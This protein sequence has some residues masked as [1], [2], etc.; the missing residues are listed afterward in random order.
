MLGIR[1]RDSLNDS[2]SCETLTAYRR[3]ISGGYRPCVLDNCYRYS[4]WPTFQATLCGACRL[5]AVP[6]PY[7]LVCRTSRRRHSALVTDGETPLVLRLRVYR[8]GAS[9]PCRG[10]SAALTGPA[11]NAMIMPA[12]RV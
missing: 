10:T 4:R 5:G 6:C 12:L 8:R 7:G 3:A 9:I 2:A 11:G 1:V